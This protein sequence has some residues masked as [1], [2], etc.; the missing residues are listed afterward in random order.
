M[1]N[2]IPHH[3]IEIKNIFKAKKNAVANDFEK[4][5]T[6]YADEIYIFKK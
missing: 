1:N 5:T 3:L 6:I 2:T 4:D